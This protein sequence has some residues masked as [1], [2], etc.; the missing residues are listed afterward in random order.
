MLHYAGLLAH[1]QGNSVKAV[2]M[3]EKSL[4]VEPDRADCYSNLGIIFRDTGRFDEA[5]ASYQKSIA[6]RPGF[7]SSHNNLA[8][9]YEHAGRT[10]E[11]IAAWQHV[12]AWSIA[13]GEP[14]RAARARS[15]LAALG[16]SAD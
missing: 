16:A 3:I 13:H 4:E 2:R 9:A 1:Q 7:V 14:A 11:A 10:A 15:H 12:L 5:I 8:I 6:I